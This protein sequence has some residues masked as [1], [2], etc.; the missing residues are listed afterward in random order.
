VVVSALSNDTLRVTVTLWP[1]ASVP[2]DGVTVSN[3]SSDVGSAIDQ[4]TGPPFAVSVSVPPTSALSDTVLGDTL[5]EPAST[6]DET[7]TLTIG[8]GAEV[9]AAGVDGA[10]VVGAAL[11]A[12]GAPD[13]ADVVLPVGGLVVDVPVLVGDV[14]RGPV[15]PREPLAPT[16][17]S[18]PARA[19]PGV[20]PDAPAVGVAPDPVAV[21][22]RWPAAWG[23]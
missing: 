2:D 9:D 14:A 19:A 16:A 1:A 20:V 3:P 12:E 21:I 15:T 8:A 17:D 11:M 18:R 10:G 5:S 7:V 13:G 4:V 6:G 23:W 22:G